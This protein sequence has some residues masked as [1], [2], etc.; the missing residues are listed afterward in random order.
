MT[1]LALVCLSIF[2]VLSLFVFEAR[3]QR[4][5]AWHDWELV[6][7]PRGE[8]VYAA[9]AVQVRDE[10]AL[11]DIALA[12]AAQFQREG[13]PVDGLRLLE[14]GTGLVQ[15][16][17][18]RLR[19]RLEQMAVLSRM[20]VAAVPVRPLRPGGFRLPP[21][22]NMARFQN[23]V[24]HLLASSAE[25]FRFKLYALRFGCGVVLR[26]LVQACERLHGAPA[27]F[28]RSPW[29][30]VEDSRRDLETL[31]DESL[32]SLRLLLTSLIA[33]PHGPSAKLPPWKM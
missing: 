30:T 27:P 15:G 22:V 24:H 9:L 17:V 28:Q 11:A 26:H 31:T 16:F 14:H 33:T 3:R 7:T 25:R 8:R 5:S 23:L 4:A 10:M 2:A 1:I 12:R 32:D 6:L 21:L 19:R 20:A 18:P 29:N 13:S